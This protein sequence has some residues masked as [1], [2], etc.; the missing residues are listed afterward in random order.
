MSKR[1]LI[2]EIAQ[3]TNQ[4][5]RVPTDIVEVRDHC[6]TLGDAIPAR[7]GSTR[8]EM[9]GF[10]EAGAEYGWTLFHPIAVKVPSGGPLT[11]DA[12]AFAIDHLERGLPCTERCAHSRTTTRK[13]RSCAGCARSSGRTFRWPSP[14][15]R[16]A[17]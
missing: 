15:I 17:T 8:E 7:F 3:E 6:A 5:K 16:T 13:P 2:A 10:L 11:D 4:F 9:G 14:S 1:V 12:F